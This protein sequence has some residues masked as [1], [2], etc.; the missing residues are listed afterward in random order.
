MIT[1]ITGAP[2]TGK[3]AALVSLLTELGKDRA[4]YVNGIPDLKIDHQELEDPTTWHDTVPDG[5]IIVIDE[6][7]R[8]WRPRGPGQKVPDHIAMLETHRHRGLDF[9]IITQSPSLIDKNVRALTGRHVHLRD[10][11]L[12]GRWWYEWPEIAENCASGWKNA[13]IKKRYRLPKKV[14]GQYKSASVHIKP[15]RSVP[16]MLAVMVLALLGTGYL[17]WR[18]YGAISGR[19]TAPVPAALT[20]APKSS[21][22]SN[23]LGLQ[24]ATAA[25]PM[26]PAFIDDRVDWIPRVSN[27]PES[28]PAF[29]ALR[30]VAVMPVVSGAIC[31]SAKTKCK[32]VTQQGTDA[33]LS[34]AECREWLE[35]PPFH[36]YQLTLGSPASNGSPAPASPPPQVYSP[37]PVPSAPPVPLPSVASPDGPALS[38]SAPRG[39]WLP[40]VGL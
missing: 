6:V 30:V 28:A 2:G 23:P 34:H 16:W 8:V 21:S 22:P 35:N 40:R 18:S 33:G 13:P 32:C 36:P 11:G 3:S 19:M 1:V 20:D 27:R 4:L 24:S 38:A 26:R 12:L 29:D 5:S 15:V 14:F 39:A 17:A 37:P 7:Q 31:N 10:I 25:A 9:Y